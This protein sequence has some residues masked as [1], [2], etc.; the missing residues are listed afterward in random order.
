[1]S[2]VGGGRSPF[3]IEVFQ[4]CPRCKGKK[5]FINKKDGFTVEDYCT[6]CNPEGL[7]SA[8]FKRLKCKTS[9]L[10]EIH[11]VPSSIKST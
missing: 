2:K 8:G 11:I 10:S 5:D 3:F 1:M 9:L 7:V 6:Y 4:I